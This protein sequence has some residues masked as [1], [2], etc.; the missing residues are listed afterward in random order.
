MDLF[1]LTEI[2]LREGGLSTWESNPCV[3]GLGS[4]GWLN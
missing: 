1:F 2:I 3:C 4:L